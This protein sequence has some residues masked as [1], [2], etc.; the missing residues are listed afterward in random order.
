MKSYKLE[1]TK[2]GLMIPKRFGAKR[3]LNEI[4]KFY[5]LRYR[6]FICSSEDAERLLN[7]IKKSHRSSED[8]VITINN[9][10]PNGIVYIN[11]VY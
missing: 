5:F 7:I 11:G 2:N 9:H 4:D 6:C 1:E 10:V 8:W 3:F